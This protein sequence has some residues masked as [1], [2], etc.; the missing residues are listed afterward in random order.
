MCC[1]V[2]ACM[3]Y[4][5][6]KCCAEWLNSV[7]SLNFLFIFDR[8]W[9]L[10]IESRWNFGCVVIW[11]D[12][13]VLLINQ[14]LLRR[15]AI[16]NPLFWQ[17]LPT[18]INK[19]STLRI[20]ACAE[21]HASSKL[22]FYLNLHHDCCLSCIWNLSCIISVHC[23]NVTRFGFLSSHKWWHVNFQWQS[24]SNEETKFAVWDFIIVRDSFMNPFSGLNEWSSSII[25]AKRHCSRRQLKTISENINSVKR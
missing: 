17:K 12:L 5:I 14:Y 8:V 23:A 19:R 13:K 6:S 22:H 4:S 7:S 18:I 16:Q 3:C 1:R 20:E 25:T 9:N 15:A 24:N 11:S 21:K 10:W 2:V